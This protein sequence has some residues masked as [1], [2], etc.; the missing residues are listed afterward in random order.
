M[1]KNCRQ[2]SFI[3]DTYVIQNYVDRFGCV[4]VR[5]LFDGMH[6]Y[7]VIKLSCVLQ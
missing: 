3:L 1:L 6:N 5:A 4:S 7:Y 2:I